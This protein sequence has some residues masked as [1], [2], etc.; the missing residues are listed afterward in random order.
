MDKEKL[1]QCLEK[2]LGRKG[3]E[4]E[5]INAEKDVGLLVPILFEKIDELEKRI[6]NL[7]KND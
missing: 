6:I 7:E 2:K 3:T 4:N 5:R 1:Q